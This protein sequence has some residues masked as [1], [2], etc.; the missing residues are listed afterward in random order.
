MKT[1][2]FLEENSRRRSE[3]NS[4]DLS[5]VVVGQRHD[6]GAGLFVA[7]EYSV[8]VAVSEEMFRDLLETELVR[9]LI[10]H[11]TKLYAHPEKQKYFFTKG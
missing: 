9:N 7:E 6:L 8:G 10:L 2:G 4:E 11:T 1:K 3:N 5:V